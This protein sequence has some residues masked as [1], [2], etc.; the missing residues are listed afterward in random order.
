MGALLEAGGALPDIMVSLLTSRREVASMSS[1]SG[2][3][4]RR[5]AQLMR[6]VA[7]RPDW[8][9]VLSDEEI[10]L[11]ECFLAGETLGRLGAARGVTGQTIRYRLF[12][13]GPQGTGGIYGRIRALPRCSSRA[14]DVPEA[15]R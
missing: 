1:Q 14:S 8:R 6:L 15:R 5:R 9:S 2:R 11:V 10:S 4:S 3:P 7:S 13:V 12:G